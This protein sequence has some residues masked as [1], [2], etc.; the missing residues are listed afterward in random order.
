MNNIS[1]EQPLMIEANES[2][3]SVQVALLLMIAL[4]EQRNGLNNIP[5]HNM[6]RKKRGQPYQM[7]ILITESDVE[8]DRRKEVNME[9]NKLHRASESQADSTQCLAA[10]QQ[11]VAN[12][13]AFESETQCTQHLT[14]GQQQEANCRASELE[15]QHTQ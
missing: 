8:K 15:A 3:V 1:S 2:A 12:C 9:H 4:F 7:E 11:Q 10:C 6:R 5:Y 14:A 13:R